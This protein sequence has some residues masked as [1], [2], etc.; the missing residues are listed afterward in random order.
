LPQAQSSL[1]SAD[2][3]YVNSVFA[4]NLAKL[5]LPR[6]TGALATTLPQTGHF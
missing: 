6:A 4:H 1:A 5:S 2:V 3:D